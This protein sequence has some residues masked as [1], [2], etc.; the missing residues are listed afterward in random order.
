MRVK[1][2]NLRVA[3]AVRLLRSERL[4]HPEN[5]RRAELSVT[6]MVCSL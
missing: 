5:R 3:P 1:L 6:G 2:G 4:D